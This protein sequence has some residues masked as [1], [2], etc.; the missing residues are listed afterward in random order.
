MLPN[1]DFN[2]KTEPQIQ[3]WRKQS[4]DVETPAK[5][6]SFGP[7]ECITLFEEA[8][9]NNEVPPSDL[10]FRCQDSC[11]WKIPLWICCLP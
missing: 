6:E 5:L 1:P 7:V 8:L 9:K 3:V 11:S 2:W 10:K 4:N